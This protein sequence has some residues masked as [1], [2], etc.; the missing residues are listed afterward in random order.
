MDGSRRPCFILAAFSEPGLHR[1][2]RVR[3]N[4]LGTWLSRISCYHVI[5]LS[6]RAIVLSRHQRPKGGD[7][8]PVNSP[9]PNQIL[10]LNL[11]GQKLSRAV[12]V[13]DSPKH[14]AE[15]PPMLPGGFFLMGLER[16]L[17]DLPTHLGLSSKK[18]ASRLSVWR[19]HGRERTA[20]PRTLSI[21]SDAFPLANRVP[22]TVRSGLRNTPTTAP[23]RLP[24]H[25]RP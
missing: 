4:R 24:K 6:Y 12:I 13:P 18:F 16:H 11:L 1:R 25:P 20:R 22:I 2:P 15:F 19:Q 3:S 10:P 14:T 5:M 9:S 7:W 17:E 8:G 23:A 21:M